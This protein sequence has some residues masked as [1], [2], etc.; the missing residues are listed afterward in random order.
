MCIVPGV[1]SSRTK[2]RTWSCSSAREAVS[3]EARKSM[4]RATRFSASYAPLGAVRFRIGSIER[5]R[6]H[7]ACDRASDSPGANSS[8]GQ[9]SQPG[10]SLALSQAQWLLERSIDPILNRT[11][12]SGAYD[13]ENLVARG[14]LFRAT[15]DTASLTELQDQVRFFVRELTTP[16]T[17][18]MGEQYGR[19]QLD[20][21][22]D[23][24]APDYVAE[25]DVP[26]V[27]EHAYLFIAA[28]TAFGSR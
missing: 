10:E 24:I 11:A 5:S 22:G 25:N 16:G 6:S 27:W 26:H 2:K 1:V 9:R 3:P 12:P 23:G 4:P 15:G 20:V 17:M 19:Y 7:C 21:N 13:A 8:T 18:H 28:M 14:M